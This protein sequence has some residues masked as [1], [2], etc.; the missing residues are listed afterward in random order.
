MNADKLR[1]YIALFGGM[2]S[3][4]YLFLEAIGVTADW[5][6][7]NVINRFNDVLI[8][9]V[10]FVIVVYGVWKNSYIVTKKAKEQEKCLKEKG[11]K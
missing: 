8:A 11:L 2:L 4:I 7:L 6:N 9:A 3:A 1:Q 10:P 5:F